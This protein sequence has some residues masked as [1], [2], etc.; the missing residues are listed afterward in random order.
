MKQ[1]TLNQAWK[2]CLAH[3]KYV[4]KHWGEG[5]DVS[6]LKDEYLDEFEKE[7]ELLNDCY[8]CE[9]N[10]QQREETDPGEEGTCL[11]CPGKLVSAR[12]DCHARAY[13]YWNKPLKFYRKLLELDKK[14]KAK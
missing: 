3:W 8:F 6:E 4:I 14:R 7:G 12:F 10:E 9:Y 2:K 5:K 11:Q 1:L 13:H